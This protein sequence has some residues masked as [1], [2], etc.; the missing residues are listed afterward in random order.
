MEVKKMARKEKRETMEREQEVA[1]DTPL[2]P[3]YTLGANAG[4]FSY[5]SAYPGDSVEEHK[6]LETANRRIAEDELKQQRD[7]L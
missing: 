7:N 5:H 3:G 4:V 2:N 6:E 1:T